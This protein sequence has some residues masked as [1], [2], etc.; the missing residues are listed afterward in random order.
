MRLKE[1]TRGEKKRRP[2]CWMADG[3][4][5]LAGPSPCG[6]R[7]KE[8]LQL[9]PAGLLAAVFVMEARSTHTERTFLR[10]MRTVSRSSLLAYDSGR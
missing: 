4:R 10:A 9:K 6:H 2:G 5:L 3:R 1:D 7:G 8:P